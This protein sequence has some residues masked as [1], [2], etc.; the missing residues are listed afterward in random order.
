M[1]LLVILLLIGLWVVTATV[2]SVLTDGRGHSPSVRS[3]ASWEAG[4]LPSVP[5]S[6]ARLW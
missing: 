1:A 3:H 5:Y 4:D 2:R 6:S